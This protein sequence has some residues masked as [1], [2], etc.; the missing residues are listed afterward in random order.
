MIEGER[1]HGIRGVT[2]HSRQVPNRTQRS[3]KTTA[4]FRHHVLGGRAKIP[5]ARVVTQA[6]PGVKD[7][8]LRRGG[9]GGEIGEAPH[10]RLII[11]DNRGDLRLLEH[12]LRNENCVRIACPAPGE[13]AAMFPIPGEECVAE[14]RGA[15]DSF[16]VGGK[17][18]TPNA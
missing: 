4:V 7:F 3:G 2:A 1:A 8:V 13:I 18:L 11:W 12:E 9:E 10:P 14:R 15:R 17:R 6:L 16:H 5:R